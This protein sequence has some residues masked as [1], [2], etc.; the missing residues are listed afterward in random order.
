MFSLAQLKLSTGKFQKNLVTFKR[1]YGVKDQNFQYYGGSLK[2]QFSGGFKKPI[3][4]GG[5]PKKG[6]LRQ[7]VGFRG[8][9]IFEGVI[10][11][12]TLGYNLLLKGKRA[13]QR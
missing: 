1:W 2:I 5:M 13:K 10:P 11:Q 6:K 12:C 7:L 9:G 4:K 3:Y 8:G